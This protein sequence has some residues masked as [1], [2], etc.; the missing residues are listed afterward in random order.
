MDKEILHLINKIIKLDPEI[1]VE[2][3]LISDDYE[4][5]YIATLI[6]GESKIIIDAITSYVDRREDGITTKVI[7]D[8]FNQDVLTLLN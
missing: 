8:Q 3:E 5:E 2:T 7:G 1:K 4:D 6:K